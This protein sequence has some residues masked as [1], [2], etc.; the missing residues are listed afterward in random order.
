M[1]LLDYWSVEKQGGK[2]D[3]VGPVDSKNSEIIFILLVKAV[4]T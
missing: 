1:L 4:A 2:K 3:L